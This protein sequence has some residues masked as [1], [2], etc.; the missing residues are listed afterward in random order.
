MFPMWHDLVGSRSFWLSYI[1][2]GVELTRCPSLHKD[3]LQLERWPSCGVVLTF[4]LPDPYMFRLQVDVGEHRLELSSPDVD[5]FMLIGTMD[6]HQMSD[7]FRWGEFEAV[8]AGLKEN[9]GPVWAHELLIGFYVAVT[10]DC[11]H[12]HL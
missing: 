5:D 12:Q 4:L 10:K 11:A 9:A 1:S 6:C 7:V 3:H 8:I 2:A